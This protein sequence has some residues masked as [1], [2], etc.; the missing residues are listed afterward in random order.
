[1]PDSRMG[2]KVLLQG[3]SGVGK[4]YSIRT[5][6][7]AG[8]TPFCL[9]TENSFEVLEDIPPEKLHWAY[10]PPSQGGLDTLLEAAQRITTMGP[11]QLQ[12]LNDTR[13]ST[14]N[15]WMRMLLLLQNFECGRTGE[16]F[17]NIST[18]D[19]SR[20]LVIDSLSGLTIAAVKAAVGEKYAMTQPEYQIAMK[21]IEN[22][23]NFLCTGISCHFVLTAHVE[24]E[25]D[26]VLGGTRL[27]PSTLGRK[28]S[29]LLPRFFSDVIMAKRQG[30]KFF[31]DTADP[32]A[33]L[34]ARNAGISADLRPSF[35]P[36]I[37]AW[38][39]RAEPVGAGKRA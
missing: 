15:T 19:T 32:T 28:L 20:A 30:T 27:Y 29:P 22:L 9:F 33:D 5:L 4:T 2:I 16:K 3:G 24:R 37:Q 8:V 11:D 21:T 38:R 17:G 14:T 6:I 7:D 23:V 18:W 39:T 10:V 34:K 31:W 1:M 26:E 35:V 12:K 13:R 25:L 36:L